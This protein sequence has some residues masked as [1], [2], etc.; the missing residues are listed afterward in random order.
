MVV[1]EKET[2]DASDQVS[3]CERRCCRGKDRNNR[4]PLECDVS[5]A[6]PYA[7]NQATVPTQAAAREQQLQN[8]RI[9]CVFNRPQELRTEEATD[10]AE[11]AGVGGVEWQ[12]RATQLAS[13][14]PQAYQRGEGHHHTEACDFEVAAPKQ[15]RVHGLHAPHG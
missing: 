9:R 15:H 5:Q 13:K 10:H 12:S 14:Q 2:T 8:W 7:P 3:E 6:N 11:N 1:T 4:P